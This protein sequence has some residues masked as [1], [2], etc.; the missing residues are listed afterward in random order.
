MSLSF[1]DCDVGPNLL[2]NLFLDLGLTLLHSDLCVDDRVLFLLVQ[3]HIDD[4]QVGHVGV[5]LVQFFVASNP[6][7]LA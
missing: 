4:L 2:C 5:V 7:F 3:L 6:E 1:Y